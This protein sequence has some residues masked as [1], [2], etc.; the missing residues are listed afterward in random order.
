MIGGLLGRKLGMTQ[1]FAEDG[2]MVPVTVIQAGPCQV[3]QVRTKAK[4]GYDAVQL[5]MDDRRRKNAT[6]AESGHARAAKTEPK[7]FIREVSL[8]DGDKVELGQTLTLDLFK[9]AKSLDVVGTTKG[10]GFQGGVKRYGFH[11]HPASH[12]ASKDHRAPGSIGSNTD[13]GHTRRGT[14]MAGH[15]GS[16]RH[17]TANLK[18]VKLDMDK[19]LLLVKGAVPGP[20]GGYVILRSCKLRKA[21][22]S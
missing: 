20:I 19:N 1:V 21:R 11:G 18:I 10:K 14:R 22:H 17:T 3:M 16:A 15:M 7:R 6:K 13:P 4:D 2:A 5:G 12:G 9:E 8:G